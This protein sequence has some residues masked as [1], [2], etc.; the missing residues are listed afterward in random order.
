MGNCSGVPS[1]GKSSYSAA[2]AAKTDVEA[3]LPHA[4]DT[5]VKPIVMNHRIEREKQKL[6]QLSEAIEFMAK[7]PEER[8]QTI[9]GP[10]TAGS[11]KSISNDPAS[12]APPDE[13]DE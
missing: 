4:T 8:D 12:E 2:A 10:G 1:T 9:A 5:A 6:F 7:T 13:L 3:L 11:L